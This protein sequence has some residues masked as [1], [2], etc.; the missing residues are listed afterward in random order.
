MAGQAAVLASCR[1]VRSAS[2]FKAFW[3]RGA[4]MRY[5]VRVTHQ[6]AQAPQPGYCLAGRS[7]AFAL[8]A[9]PLVLHNVQETH[10]LLGGEMSRRL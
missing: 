7:Q 9:S 5:Q 4:E 6:A 3:H 1:S 2:T 10:T 8:P